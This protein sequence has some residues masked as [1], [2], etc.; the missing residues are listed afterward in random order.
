MQPLL[1]LSFFPTFLIIVIAAVPLVLDRIRK[2]IS[3]QVEGRGKFFKNLFNFAI[4]YKKFWTKRG[5]KT[6]VLNYL[7]CRKIKA[8]LGGR[9][10]LL[11][12]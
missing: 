3:E 5:F 7:I 6:P 8:L 11:A 10:R 12:W 9:C 2:N 1:F 4:E